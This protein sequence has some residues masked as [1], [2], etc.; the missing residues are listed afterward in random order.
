MVYGAF[1]LGMMLV[2]QSLNWH[3][4]TRTQAA[5]D[6]GKADREQRPAL[7]LSYLTQPHLRTATLS[8]NNVGR[9]MAFKGLF[10]VQWRDVHSVQLREEVEWHLYA[11]LEYKWKNGFI[12]RA[13]LCVATTLTCDNVCK[14]ARTHTRAKLLAI[15][16]V[17]HSV[18]EIVLGSNI[19]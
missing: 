9:I 7:S 4:Q 1:A 19:S 3:T 13:C 8:S 18:R 12:C 5:A 16:K 15:V 2:G 11:S 14:L 6:V 17:C 10:A